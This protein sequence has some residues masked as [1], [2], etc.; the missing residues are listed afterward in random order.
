[1]LLNEMIKKY[2]ASDYV[3]YVKSVRKKNQGQSLA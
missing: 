2:S 1:M 3:D